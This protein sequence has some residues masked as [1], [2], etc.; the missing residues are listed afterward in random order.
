M[1]VLPLLLAP[2]AHLR[3][4]RLAVSAATSDQALR[5]RTGAAGRG[6]LPSSGQGLS[7]PPLRRSA[8]CRVA[9]YKNASRRAPGE[10]RATNARSRRCSAPP[11]LRTPLE[12]ALQ[13]SLPRHRRADLNLSS[14][15]SLRP[16]LGSSMVSALGLRAV[17]PQG[18]RLALQAT[19]RTYH[20]TA[21]R[22]V[23]CRIG[24]GWCCHPAA[25][26]GASAG[27]PASPAPGRCTDPHWWDW[28]GR[29][30]KP[31]HREGHAAALREAACPLPL[32]RAWRCRLSSLA[33]GRPSPRRVGGALEPAG[34][35]LLEIEGRLLSSRRTC[36]S[37]AAAGST[38]PLHCGRGFQRLA[39][40][41]RRRPCDRPLHRHPD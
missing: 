8:C 15:Q 40:H 11:F 39:R 38:R 16:A 1:Y 31:P 28:E 18:R 33:M 19:R 10:A 29:L 21:I 25:G 3:R 32:C 6:N 9:K 20:S 7:G 36:H 4:A 22:A 17:L 12:R 23:S 13:P 34:H 26:S 35:Q 24:W 5:R 27:A 41:L 37:S 2:G 30:P 14:D